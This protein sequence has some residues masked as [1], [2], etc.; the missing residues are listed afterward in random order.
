MKKILFVSNHSGKTLTNFSLSSAAASKDIGCEFIYAA[1]ISS[2]LDVSEQEK[3][4]N[5]KIKHIDF[6]RRIFNVKQHVK[7]YKEIKEIILLESI[8][9]VHANTPIG[10]ALARIAAK[11][12]KVDSILYEVHGF[13]F[14][15][16]NNIFLNTIFFFMEYLLSKI[17]DYIV[18]MNEED[19]VAAKK[20][21]KPHAVFKING[22]GINLEELKE[23][24]PDS[25]YSNKSKFKCV[26]VGELTK[27]KKQRFLLEVFSGLDSEKYELVLCGKGPEEKKLK[28]IIYDKNIKNV[29]VLGYRDDIKYIL[30]QSD[31][32]LFPSKR[33]G[34][35]RAIMEAMGSGL[36]IITARTRGCVDLVHHNF[37]G[38]VLNEYNVIEYQNAIKKLAKDP[39][40]RLEMSN[41]NKTRIIDYKFENVKKEMQ[42][43]YKRA[44][45]ISR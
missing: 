11:N 43:I 35:P 20:M 32:F 37:G 29:K 19:F 28:E 45:E 1:N 16:G 27:S 23:N 12:C 9:Y 5:I 24:Y 30:S 40:L 21:Y 10:G 2:M 36:P 25:V 17:T 26:M 18:T 41:Y 13:H 42:E 3:K 33:E 34:L 38:Y 6:S 4:Y 15:R 31:C 22:V 44:F 39:R 8:D 14:F 7:A